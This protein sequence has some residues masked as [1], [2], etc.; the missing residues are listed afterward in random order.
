[1]MAPEL[2]QRRGRIEMWI[3][4]GDVEEQNFD[5]F[6]VFLEVEEAEALATALLDNARYA[7]NVLAV[8]ASNRAKREAKEGD[9]A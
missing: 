6:S 8:M 5:G 4:D 9:D 2:Y 1:M 7:R 3:S